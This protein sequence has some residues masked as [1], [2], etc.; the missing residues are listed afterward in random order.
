M[1]EKVRDLEGRPRSNIYLLVGL[2]GEI[3]REQREYIA[4]E[5]IK[6]PRAK[7]RHGLI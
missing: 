1:G 2:E 3:Q 4:E 6:F 7:E 5:I